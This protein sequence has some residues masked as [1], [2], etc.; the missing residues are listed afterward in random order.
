MKFT[1]SPRAALVLIFAMFIGPLLVA[2]LMYS[3]TISY[4]PGET[5]N[6]GTLVQPAVP[7]DWTQLSS[8]EGVSETTPA[9]AFL[10][11]WV[12]LHP[13]AAD[14]DKGCINRAISLRQVHKA[15]GRQ[16]IRIRLALLIPP[17]TDTSKLAAL[18][19]I[20]GEFMLVTSADGAFQARLDSVSNQA[21]NYLIDPLGN[22]MM[23]YA[24]GSDPN[25]LK[26][27]LKRL[28]TWSKL[29]EQ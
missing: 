6:Y 18:Q 14:C 4:Q 13:V 9:E 19:D 27:D 20:Y 15:S 10:T 17:G 16:A 22:I 29:D 21:E 1:L 11:H 12:V 25:D 3:G 5:R 2:W 23:Y 28:L 8:L 26:Q 7:I 24:V